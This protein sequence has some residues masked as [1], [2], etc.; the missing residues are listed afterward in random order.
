MTLQ[1]LQRLLDPD[2]A[3]IDAALDRIDTIV[4]TPGDPFDRFHN[5][6]REGGLYRTCTLL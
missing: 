4:D 5:R 6:I 3:F 2:Q 1:H